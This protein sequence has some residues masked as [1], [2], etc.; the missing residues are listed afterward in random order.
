MK[1]FDGFLVLFVAQEHL[2]LLEILLTFQHLSL[3][4]KVGGLVDIEYGTTGDVGGGLVSIDHS[5]AVYHSTSAINLRLAVGREASDVLDSIA[6][7]LLHLL[8]RDP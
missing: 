5:I 3:I 7:L 1:G 4:E 2:A 6:H 8:G